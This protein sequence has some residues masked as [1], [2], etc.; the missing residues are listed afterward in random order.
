M[1]VEITGSSDDTIE[2][3]GDI[4]AELYDTGFGAGA[5]VCLSNGLVLHFELGE[6][7]VWRARVERGDASRV[8]IAPGDGTGDDVVFCTEPVEWVSATTDAPAFAR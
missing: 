7:E 8:S 6:G 4:S 2:V 1:A 3:G 5:Y